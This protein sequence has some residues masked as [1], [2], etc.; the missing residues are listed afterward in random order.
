M[1]LAGRE[2]AVREFS[3]DDLVL[4]LAPVAAGDIDG[5]GWLT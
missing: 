4:R 1:G 2:R 5:L 3:Y